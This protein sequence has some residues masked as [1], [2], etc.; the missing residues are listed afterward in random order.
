M[1]LINNQSNNENRREDIS[2]LQ[3]LSWYGDQ[4]NKSMKQNRKCLVCLPEKEAGISC[5]VIPLWVLWS[6]CASVL[7]EEE[8]ELEESFESCFCFGIKN[9]REEEEGLVYR[10]V[11]LRFN[12]MFL[13]L[14]QLSWRF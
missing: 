8:W 13:C 6:D 12:A 10:E 11:A 5:S 1:S 14:F 9:G 4:K 3:K 7:S 2:N